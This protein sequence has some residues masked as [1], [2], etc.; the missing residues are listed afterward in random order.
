MG[1]AH[2][3]WNKPLAR[4]LMSR[5][6]Q[7]KRL[8]HVVQTPMHRMGVH[9][10]WTYLERLMYSPKYI[11]EFLVIL[12]VS[13]RC[14]IGSVFQDD[15]TL[16]R[17]SFMSELIHAFMYERQLSALCSSRVRLYDTVELTPD[18]RLRPSKV[19]Y[20][21]GL[22]HGCFLTCAKNGSSW[23]GST[24]LMSPEDFLAYD[25]MSYKGGPLGNTNVDYHP[26]NAKAWARPTLIISQNCK[27][28]YRCC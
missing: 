6:M 19:H 14:F 9:R 26:D 11:A 23:W 1:L 24:L 15:L 3:S 7:Y 2:R 27:G 13:K 22:A 17:I 4:G 25:I 16:R 21:F 28:V 8:S 5:A 20:T 10:E 18:Y 12:S